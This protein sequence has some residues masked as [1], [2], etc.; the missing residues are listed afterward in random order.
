MGEPTGVSVGGWGGGKH[1]PLRCH[2]RGD[3]ADRTRQSLMLRSQEEKTSGWKGTCTQKQELTWALGSE[4]WRKPSPSVLCTHQ[5]PESALLM[6]CGPFRGARITLPV[7]AKT[8]SN[9]AACPQP[10]YPMH[11]KVL[12]ALTSK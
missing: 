10:P 9:L 7:K 1:S 12:L 5:T 8:M 3:L 2:L 4:V 6:F 11:R